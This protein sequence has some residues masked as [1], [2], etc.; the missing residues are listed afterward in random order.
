MGSASPLWRT[1]SPLS[2]ALATCDV[3]ASLPLVG[4]HLEPLGTLTAAAAWVS[5][6]LSGL[7]NPAH[8][9]PA[10]EAPADVCD[11]PPAAAPPARRASRWERV[12]PLLQANGQR[13]RYLHR[14]GVRYG[15]APQQ[16]LDVWRRADLTAPAPVAVFV[17]G[18]GW[19]HGGRMLQGYSLMS[20]LAEL[21]WLCLS[22]EYRV[23]PRHRWPRHVRDVKAAIAWARAH[24]GDFGGD[25]G[26]VAIAGCSAGGHLAALGG[27]TPGDRHFDAEL[28]ASADTSVD[29]V[30]GLYGRYDWVDRSTRERDDFVHFLEQIVVRERMERTPETFAQASPIARTHVAA[31]P[32]LVVHGSADR[33]IPVA[34]AR[35]FVERLRAT[36]TSVVDYLELPGAGH[37]FDLIDPVH[38]R[39]CTAAVGDFL[40]GA[41]RAHRAATRAAI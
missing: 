28:P 25:P 4:R 35:D 9:A 32:F 23:A 5:R 7:L 40:G 6:Y 15:D 11:T 31:P 41:Y 33:V 16:L 20:H 22:V 18:G 26:F 30:V 17:P 2:L 27:L 21:G 13:R 24:A 34:Q 36:S 37:A 29:A 12:S 10:D 1:P 14:S 38:T 19:V 39:T 3:S 8:E